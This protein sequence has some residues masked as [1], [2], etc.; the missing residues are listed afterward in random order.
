MSERSRSF[1]NTNIEKVV[2]VTKSLIFSFCF[3]FSKF[4]M[5]LCL[6]VKIIDKIHRKILSY[7]GKYCYFW[8]IKCTNYI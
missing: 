5:A 8:L 7:N 3:L 2:R 4:Y 1:R 6:Q